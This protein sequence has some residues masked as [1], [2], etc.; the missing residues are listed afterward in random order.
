MAEY[1]VG[2]G[3]WVRNWVGD[4]M[5]HYCNHE[6]KRQICYGTVFVNW[7]FYCFVM[8]KCLF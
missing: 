5:H 3:G 6:K 8:G 4:T 7:Y 1:Y 2:I